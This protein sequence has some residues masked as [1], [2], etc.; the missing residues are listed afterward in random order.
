MKGVKI[1]GDLVKYVH[2]FIFS[3]LMDSE[4]YLNTFSLVIKMILFIVI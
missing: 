3:L 2:V 1:T 4:Y